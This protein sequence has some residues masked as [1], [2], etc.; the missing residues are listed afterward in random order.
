[1][2]SKFR[3][4]GE[5]CWPGSSTQAYKYNYSFGHALTCSQSICW[6]LSW[7]RTVHGTGDK[8][9]IKFFLSLQGAHR[10]VRRTDMSSIKCDRESQENSSKSKVPWASIWSKMFGNGIEETFKG[11][12]GF[13]YQCFLRS[14]S[15]GNRNKNKNKQIGPNQPY[16]LLHSKGNHKQNEKATYRMGENTC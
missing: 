12:A 3:W 15:Q 4:Y 7:L 10:P 2:T 6:A 16:K 14:V 11:G 5:W 13:S 1:M 8:M 9:M